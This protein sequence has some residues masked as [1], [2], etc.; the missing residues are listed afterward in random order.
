MHLLSSD[1]IERTG[2][3]PLHA[4]GIGIVVA[5]PQTAVADDIWWKDGAIQACDGAV[6]V[7]IVASPARI[8]DDRMGGDEDGEERK[9]CRCDR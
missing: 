5:H 3:D 7:E 1:R 4:I 9:E 6:G 8:C 2:V